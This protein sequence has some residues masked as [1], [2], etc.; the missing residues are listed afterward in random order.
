MR[1]CLP[2]ALL[3][4]LVSSSALAQGHATALSATAASPAELRAW[5]QQVDSMVRS[6]ELRVRETASDPLLAGRRHE[7]LDQYIRGVRIFGGDLTR[8]TESN[9]TVSLFGM[10][11]SG[12]DLDTTPRLPADAARNAIA[13]AGGGAA[14][15]DPELV[16]LPLSDGYHLAYYGRVA[17]PLDQVSVFVDANSGAVLRQYSEFISEIVAG[18]GIYGDDKKVS[19]TSSSGARVANDTMRPGAITTYDMKGDFAHTTNILNVVTP[20]VPSDIASSADATWTDSI[21]VDAHVYAG[22]YYDYLYKRFG[23]NGIDN[24]NLRMALFTHPVKLADI[25]TA[26]SSVVGLYYINAFFCSTCGPNG[27]GAIVLGEGAPKN[28]LG[29]GIEVKPFAAALD[30]V[31][32]ELTHAV[33]ASTARLNGFPYSEA[34]ALNEAFSDVIGV[35]TEFYYEPAGSAPLQ[36]SYLQGRD[37]TVPA[38]VIGRNL[39]V[40]GATGADHYTRRIIGGDPHYNG[41]ILGHA[42]YLAIEGGTNKTSGLAVQGVGAANREQIEKSFFRAL[43]VLLPSSATFALVRVAT[44]QAARDLYGS[45]SAAER[46]ITQAWDAVGVQARTDPTATLLPNPAQPY[47]GVCNGMAT[48]HWLLY[49]TVSAGSS[50]LRVTQWKWDDHSSAEYGNAASLRL[51]GT[52]SGA[53]FAAAFTGCGPGSD[54]VVAQSDACALF[55]ADLL[56]DASG[57]T[58]ITFTAVDDAGRTLTFATPRVTLSPPR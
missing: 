30:V 11:H 47:T 20:V 23:R 10:L 31:A 41:V 2:A 57:S 32:H 42:Y 36:A 49:V 27:R 29:P 53:Q 13:G 34:G 8:Q 48:P 26:P 3:C 58:Q 56:G 15:G 25:N 24:N 1:H 17:A 50:N 6:G 40:P 43:T 45:G 22:W 19:V 4:M 44:I 35:G 18:K 55:C 9:L 52:N 38:G 21:V 37:L 16:V 46:A 51:T 5:D 54:R 28:Y 14:I 12:I 33:T 39:A 7:R